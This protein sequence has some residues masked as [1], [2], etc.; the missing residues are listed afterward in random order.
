[1]V[2]PG[3]NRSFGAKGLPGTN[4][5]NEAT[6]ATKTALRLQEP[7]SIQERSDQL[8][9]SVPLVSCEPLCLPTP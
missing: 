3:A 5:Y 9:L 2:P 6:G 1:M 7:K 8:A 4:S